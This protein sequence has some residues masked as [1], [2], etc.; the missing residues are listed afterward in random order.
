[1]GGRGV[2]AGGGRGARTQIYPLVYLSAPC[3]SFSS[4]YPPPRVMEN[5]KPHFSRS[6]RL[7]EMGGRKLFFYLLLNPSP[8]VS[9]YAMRCDVMLRYNM[10]CG[11]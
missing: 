3:R 2:I 11:A 10:L 9:C 1:M 4:P 7:E 5:Y 8:A 6:G